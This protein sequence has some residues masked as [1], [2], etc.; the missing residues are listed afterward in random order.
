MAKKQLIAAVGYL[1]KSTKGKKSNGKERQ[2]KSIGQQKTEIIELASRHGY[3]I[4]RWYVDEGVSG[5]KRNGKRPAF[6]SMLRDAR[7]RK[8]F[9]A[10]LCDDLDRFSRA[11]VMEV[12]SDLS[13]LASGGVRTIHCVNQGEYGLGENDIGRII[14]M[15][16][17]VHGGNDFSRKLGRR[18]AIARRNAALE[19]KRMGGNAPYGYA[20]D[21]NGGLKIGDR[22]QVRIVRRI[23]DSFV[24]D[25][26]A[27]NLIADEL[28][29]AGIV[30]PGG[31]RWYSA[32][33]KMILTCRAYRG[34]FEYNRERRGKFFR[35]DDKG[36]VIEATDDNR[37]RFADNNGIIVAKGVHPAIIDAK[38]WDK[39]QRRRE[40]LKGNRGRRK[41]TRY[42]LTGILVCDHCGGPLHGCQPNS[43]VVYRCGA[44]SRQGKSACHPYQVRQCEVLP[45]LMRMLGEE[46][47]NVE[48]MLSAPPDKLR[49]PNR[50]RREAREQSE[51]DR[52]QLAAKIAT[53]EENLLFS[54]DPRNRQALDKR[55]SALRDQLEAL[56]A[57]LATEV[58]V[59][60]YTN[61]DLDRLRTWWEEFDKMAV[62]VPVK[63]RI[64]TVAH[65]YQDPASD[66]Q[67]LLID[68]RKINAALHELGTEVRLR[69]E[70]RPYKTS[71]GKTRSRYVLV[72]G[73]FR[74]GQKSGNLPRYVLESPAVRPTSFVRRT[75]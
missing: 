68:A 38:L 9:E 75:R 57:Q 14:K 64:P 20:N 15:V 26:K 18:I 30:S 48:R 16:V 25:A 2:E 17:D 43:Y 1:R 74:L 73:R 27:M 56:D 37:Q 53:A 67:A 60:T 65:L 22:K 33:I 42:A 52:E 50:D 11:D 19:G 54:D 63:G 71:G 55:L 44:P 21:G 40:T 61:E 46:I 36:E 59:D 10:I 29:C 28:N 3:K 34:D 24:N 13:T 58:R 72:R 62:S 41:R 49:R 23:F 70:N 69:W 7:D 66:E 12:F 45:F 5:W 4:V 39:A 51:N 6:D 8:D 31:G 32:S 47:Q 35:I